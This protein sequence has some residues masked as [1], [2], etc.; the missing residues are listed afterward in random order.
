MSKIAD[1]E[2]ARDERKPICEFCGEAAHKGMYSCPRISSVT[3]NEEETTV[4][5]RFRPGSN[6]LP[7]NG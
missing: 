3:V 2:R 7:S 5:V 1:L 6:D 4:T